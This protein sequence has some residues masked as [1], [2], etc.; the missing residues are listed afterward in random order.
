MIEPCSMCSRP[1]DFQGPGDIKVHYC[2]GRF[3]VAF[4]LSAPGSEE[5]KARRPV[6][7]E[8]GT[9]RNLEDG[10]T[11]LREMRPDWF[12]GKCRYEYRITN[13]FDVPQSKRMTGRSEADFSAVK[14]RADEVA[15]DLQGCNLVILC[16]K[17][18]QSLEDRL[19]MT[20]KGV[21]FARVCHPGA[22][23]LSATYRNDVLRMHALPEVRSKERVRRWAEDVCKQLTGTDPLI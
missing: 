12:P 2:K 22:R 15:E 14:R 11:L 3:P 18:A 5:V 10:L 4:V 8:R 20:M 17:R 1:L 13:A 7:G 23:G 9:G 21:V 19:R 6:A 16:G